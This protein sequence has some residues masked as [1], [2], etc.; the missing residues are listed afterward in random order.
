[1]NRYNISI[2][3]LSLIRMNMLAYIISKEYS[4]VVASIILTDINNTIYR[5]RSGLNKLV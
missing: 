2:T 4:M 1:M 3:E 5:N